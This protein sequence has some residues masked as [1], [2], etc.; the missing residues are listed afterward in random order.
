[1]KIKNLLVLTIILFSVSLFAQV[2]RSKMPEPGPAPE[3]KIN[4]AQNFTLDNGL[5]VFVVENHKIPEVSF[6]IIFNYNP[7]YEGKLAG[8]GE[9]TGS[10]LGTG[11]TTKTKDQIDESVDFIGASLSTSAK[12]VY[13][14]VLKKNLDTFASIMGDVIANAKFSESELTKIQKRTISS[15][16]ANEK[17]PSA[18]AE[19][20]KKVLD[21]GS[22]SPYGEIETEKS[23]KAVTLDKCIDFYNKYMR[24]NDSYLAIVGDI[25]LDEAEEI[26]EKYFGGWKKGNVPESKFKSKRPP[27][28]RKVALVDRPASVQ[29]IIHITYPVKFTPKSNDIFAAR[30]ANAIL[31]GAFVS[32]LNMNLREKH[33]YTY[34]ARSMLNPDLFMGYFDASCEARNEVTDSAVTQFLL[35]M[36]KMRSEKVTEDELNTV[37]KYMIGQFAR[38]LE[39]PSTVARFA[40]NIERYNLPKDY[41]KNYLKNLA[42]VTVDDVYKAAKKYINP[43]KAYVLVVGN[44]D[45]VGKKLKKFSLSGKIGYYDTYGNK[46]DPD[47]K[48]LSA[49]ITVDKV[50]GK[51]LNALGGKEKLLSIKDETVSMQGSI[52][53]MNMKITI[54]RKF[55]NKYYFNLDLGAMQQVQKFDGEK[56][57]VSGM[58][59]EQKLEGEQLESMKQQSEMYP[60]ARYR[61]LGIKPE[62]AGLGNVNGKDAYKMRL[63]FPNGNKSVIYIDTETGLK[64]REESSRKTRQGTFSTTVDYSDYKEWDGMKYPGK[65]VQQVGPQTIEMTVSEVKTNS[66]VKDDFFKVD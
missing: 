7:V 65:I 32:R 16:K 36:K 30:V 54:V 39:K 26:A 11:T 53:G 40:I 19:N 4:D 47:A 28:I 50:I 62:L 63:T 51:Y 21:F 23:V 64:L 29:S 6:T 57:L 3:I 59:Q 44:G 38:S 55:P 9:I 5:K 14:N 17:S 35:E 1:M 56:A 33:A 22:D 31:G 15:L 66:G 34:G 48:K 42:A 43:D 60:L 58:G 61:E 41:Y 18:I 13:G 45:E 2:D 20:V 37:K 49:D 46:V 8:L 24:P 27:L 52:Q 12:G 25:N 10:L